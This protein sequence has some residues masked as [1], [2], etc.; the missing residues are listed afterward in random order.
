MDYTVAQYG[1]TENIII[2]SDI[3]ICSQNIII[4]NTRYYIAFIIK[5]YQIT[6]CDI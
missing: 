2:T 4:H 6:N 3:I 5:A 1:F